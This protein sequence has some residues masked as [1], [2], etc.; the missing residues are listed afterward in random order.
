MKVCQVSL[1]VVFHLFYLI[2]YIAVFF[3]NKHI[4]ELIRKENLPN[5][6]LF[7]PDT[8]QHIF[9]MQCCGFNNKEMFSKRFFL[10][11]TVLLQFT[12]EIARF[13]IKYTC[14]KIDIFLFLTC[15][16]HGIIW[17]RNSHGIQVNAYCFLRKQSIIRH[18]ILI[19]NVL[20]LLL[21]FNWIKHELYRWAIQ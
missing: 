11:N 7:I 3:L 17:Y 10:T 13:H 19:A 21:V 6:C 16:I 14:A 4:K 18:L 12:M 1:F 15:F 20:L 5:L 9:T 2:I 8:I